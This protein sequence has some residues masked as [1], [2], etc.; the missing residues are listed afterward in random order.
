MKSTIQNVAR[1][2]WRTMSLGQRF[3]LLQFILQIAHFLSQFISRLVGGVQFFS[4]NLNFTSEF[5]NFY[6][7]IV[8]H[9]IQRIPNENRKTD[10]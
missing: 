6:N 2:S 8:F 9:N 7:Q 1:K 3:I 10:E 4:Q 5:V